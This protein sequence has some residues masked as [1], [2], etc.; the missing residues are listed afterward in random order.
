MAVHKTHRP[1]KNPLAPSVLEILREIERL[2]GIR[3]P[4]LPSH[5]NAE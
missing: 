5:Q 2:T 3:R 1:R 4:V